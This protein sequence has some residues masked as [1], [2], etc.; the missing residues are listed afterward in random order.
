MDSAYEK[1]DEKTSLHG[2]SIDRGVITSSYKAT[3]CKADTDI[4]RPMVPA[5]GDCMKLL[6]SLEHSFHPRVATSV[7]DSNHE[8]E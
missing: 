7:T 2:S 8:F 4:D 3:Q 6:W 1:L 5:A